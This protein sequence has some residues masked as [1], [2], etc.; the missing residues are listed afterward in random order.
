MTQ[1]SLLFS[2]MRVGAMDVR[3]RVVMSPMITNSGDEE[4]HV[5]DQTV[6]YYT[7]RARG[8]VGLRI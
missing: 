2:P 5:T 8:E 1:F 3:N 6:A 4:G 7:A